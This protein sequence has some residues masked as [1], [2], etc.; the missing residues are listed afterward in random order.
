MQ[1]NTTKGHDLLSSHRICQVLCVSLYIYLF[2]FL[3]SQTNAFEKF[4]YITHFAWLSDFDKAGC[5][6]SKMHMRLSSGDGIICMGGI[7][8]LYWQE[9]W[10]SQS[11]WVWFCRS[12]ITKA[13]KVLGVRVQILCTSPYSQLCLEIKNASSSATYATTF[14]WPSSHSVHQS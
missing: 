14:I 6:G 2:W 13:Q 9:N 3:I 11:R 5:C 4:I 7:I 10:G 8:P 1:P 12:Y